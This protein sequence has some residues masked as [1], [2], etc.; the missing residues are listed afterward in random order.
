MEFKLIL[1]QII[2]HLLADFIFQTQKMSEKKARKVLSPSHFYHVLIVGVASYGLS[3]DLGFW[4][5]ALLLTIIHLLTDI[6]KSWLV[7]KNK[8][9]SYFFLD[10]FI[11]IITIV[12]IVFAYSFF[13]GIDFLIDLNLKIVAVVAAFVFC[14]KPSNI[15]IKYIFEA[16]SI[17]T[18]EEN[19]ENPGEQSLPNAGKLIGIIERFLALALIIMGQYQAVGLIIAAKSILRFNGVQKSEYVLIG[20]LLSFGIAAFSGILVNM[21]V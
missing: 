4:K 3:F 20:T 13:F 9:R 21:I 10:Q 5:A 18:P 8:T 15:F 17:E 19:S 14:A 1:L 6:F 12:G 16:F 2:A 11:H 7:L